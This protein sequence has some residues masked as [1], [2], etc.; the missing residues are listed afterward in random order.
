[1]GIICVEGETEKTWTNNLSSYRILYLQEYLECQED[2]EDP[3][4]DHDRGE[5]K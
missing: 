5:L 3:E 1:M 2:Q 4:K